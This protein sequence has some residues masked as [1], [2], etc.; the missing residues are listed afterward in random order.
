MTFES[1]CVLL[2]QKAARHCYTPQHRNKNALFMPKR[3]EKN[4]SFKL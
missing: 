3:N 2:K 4:I 1:I